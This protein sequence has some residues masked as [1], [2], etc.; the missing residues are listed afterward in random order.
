MPHTMSADDR[1][2]FLLA[3]GRTGHLAT[4]REDG[5]AHVAPVWFTL[6]GDDVLFNTGA[7]TVKGRNLRRTGRAALSVDLPMHPYGFV[8]LEGPVHVD[9]DHEGFREWSRIIAARYVPHDEVDA[10][11]DRNAVPGELLIRLTPQTVVAVNELA[12]WD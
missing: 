2:A 12:G 1:R 9:D 3:P 6:D 7:D 10:Y 8:H 11:A 5:R 4:V